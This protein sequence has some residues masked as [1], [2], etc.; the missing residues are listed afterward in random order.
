MEKLV[1]SLQK[2][3]GMEDRIVRPKTIVS[4]MDNMCPPVMPKEAKSFSGPSNNPTDLEIVA[5]IKQ[6]AHQERLR[7]LLCNC[8]RCPCCKYYFYITK[9]GRGKRRRAVG[10]GEG[11]CEAAKEG[12]VR[13]SAKLHGMLKQLYSNEIVNYKIFPADNNSVIVWQPVFEFKGATKPKVVEYTSGET[14]LH[15]EDIER[16]WDRSHFAAF[17]KGVQVKKYEEKI[18]CMPCAQ[19]RARKEKVKP[20][21]GKMMARMEA[22]NQNQVTATAATVASWLVGLI[23]RKFY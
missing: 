13:M 11:K 16:T 20:T 23:G 18:E 6:G 22:T 3:T 2:K 1:G 14:W 15:Y 8:H 7:E 4:L 21:K 9:K 19:S 10:G 17:A 12:V 5:K